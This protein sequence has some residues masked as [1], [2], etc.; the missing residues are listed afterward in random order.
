VAKDDSND[1]LSEEVRMAVA[2]VKQRADRAPSESDV[3]NLAAEALAR[4]HASPAEVKA[5]LDQAIRH[6]RLI[7][8]LAESLP[9]EGGGSGGR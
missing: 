7:G 3:R 1:P 8:E 9:D 5:I 4:G 2:A 6:V